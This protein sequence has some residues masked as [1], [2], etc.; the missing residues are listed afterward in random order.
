MCLAVAQVLLGPI[1]AS[2]A[3][4][5]DLGKQRSAIIQT[6][7]ETPRPRQAQGSWEL[8][9]VELALSRNTDLLAPLLAPRPVRSFSKTAL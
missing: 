3:T 6:A 1:G 8:A 2:L 4:D 5:V 7:L 9:F